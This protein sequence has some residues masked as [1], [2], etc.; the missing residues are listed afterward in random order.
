MDAARRKDMRGA[1][2]AT[3]NYT[4]AS[5]NSPS[6]TDDCIAELWGLL[7]PDI[8]PEDWNKLVLWAAYYPG[9]RNLITTI[10]T[11]MPVVDDLANFEEVS[12]VLA[13]GTI[14]RLQR[15]GGLDVKDVSSP[16]GGEVK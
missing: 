12:V 15:A 2:D 6:P 8:G 3:L 5:E 4:M 14:R 13:A 1:A 9:V 11:Q 16:D 7:C 10:A